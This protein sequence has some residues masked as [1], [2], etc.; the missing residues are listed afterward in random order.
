MCS[1]YRFLFQHRQS[2]YVRR[3]IGE[4]KRKEEKRDREEVEIEDAEEGDVTVLGSGDRPVGAVVRRWSSGG[5]VAPAYVKL[6]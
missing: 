1:C 2:P 4:E 3:R 6:N 5:G